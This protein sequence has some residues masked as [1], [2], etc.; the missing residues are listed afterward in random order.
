MSSILF[1]DSGGLYLSFAQRLTKEFDTVYYFNEWEYNGDDMRAA[2]YIIGKGIQGIEKVNSV[3]EA[4]DKADV[5]F[6]PYCTKM[7]E[8]MDLISQ[9]Y[10]VF[11]SGSA[12]VLENDRFLFMRKIE[13]KELPSIK[14]EV[15]KSVDE[16]MGIL[17]RATGDK[18]IKINMFRRDMQT[19]HHWSIE[20]S[21][22]F[23]N[24]LKL[25][26]GTYQDDIR[27]I[28]EDPVDGQECGVDTYCIEGKLPSVTMAG[29]ELKNKAYIG[30]MIPTKKLPKGVKDNIE[31][32]ADFVGE[33]G[34]S[35]FFSDEERVHKNKFYLTDPTMRLPCFSEDT[36]VLTDKGWKFFYDLDRTEKVCTLNPDNNNIEYH[37]PYHYNS[38][39]HDGNLISI[40]NKQ[41][42][43]ECLVTPDH[44]TWFLDRYKNKLHCT[45]SNDLPS[46][47]FIPRTGIWEGADIKYF[48]LPEYKNSW[49]SGG[50]N[51]ATKLYKEKNEPKLAIPMD[52]WLDFLGWYISE[53]SVGCHGYT[54]NI[55]QK[56]YKN[57]VR[58]CLDKLPFSYLED[59][60]NFQIGSI[61]LATYL[62]DFG[63]CYEKY[64]P[65]YV[66]ISSKRLINIFLNSYNL[67]DGAS[68]DRYHTRY[69]TTSKKLADDL[70]ELTL[71]SGNVASIIKGN[72]KGTIM[73]GL[74]KEYIRKND[75]Y[76]VS[77]SKK[78]HDFWFETGARKSQYVNEKEYNG[79]VY[80]LTVQNHV[81]Y[82]RR[83]GKPFWSGNCPPNECHQVNIRN[84]GDI[85]LK[86]AIGELIEPDY[87]KEYIAQILITSK[88]VRED[89]T[90]VRFPKE[91]EDNVRLY[92]Y[93]VRDGK[94]FVAPSTDPHDEIIC[95]VVGIGSTVD[96]AIEQ[97]LSHAGQVEADGLCFNKHEF[98]D[99]KSVIEEG[100]NNGITIFD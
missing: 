45:A 75:D 12:A 1:V 82:V 69:F 60:N 41:K 33:C 20:S 35:C 70:Q 47:G 59:E 4:K 46:K 18:Y 56:K 80:D 42:T 54:V 61:Q 25:N 13:E 19:Y 65:D 79:M 93:T 84:L 44:K 21:R 73:K 88:T 90:Y 57:E 83:N 76:T 81:I 43:I 63:L 100:S 72:K 86:G 64:V 55:S 66:K 68:S 77:V 48:Y 6:Y 22:I 52:N 98:I 26:I 14:H 62:K 38:H 92:N 94:H 85:I 39:R 78:N 40:S 2:N 32:L 31:F 7:D 87:I 27:F 53:G 15:V 29:Y 28:V 36:E 49:Y 67:G 74:K 23:F 34:V 3:A 8:Q 11:G 16:L 58:E 24:R 95:S 17:E 5:I 37:L 96:E 97:C 10:K 9:G 71:K 50:G 30:R 51:G 89:F 91:I 99:A